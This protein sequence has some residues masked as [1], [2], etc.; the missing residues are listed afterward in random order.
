MKI[1]N[2]FESI[3]DVIETDMVNI[4]VTRIEKDIVISEAT[5]E[6]INQFHGFVMGAVEDAVEAA[7]EEDEEAAGRII[8]MH[9]EVARLADEAGIHG[10]KRLV[11]DEPNRL[12]AYT[13]EMELVERIKRIYYFAK[14]IAETVQIGHGGRPSR[15][16]APSERWPAL[17]QHRMPSTPPKS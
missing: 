14:R 10:A 17:S 1:A 16:I 2:A 15:L 6:L 4:G 8:E 12:A 5:V 9:G 3:G 13:R 7:G 11:A